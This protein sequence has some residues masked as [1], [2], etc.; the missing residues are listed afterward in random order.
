ML[1]RELNRIELA[2]DELNL[3]MALLSQDRLSEAEAAARR[4]VELAPGEPSGHVNLIAALRR[5][6]NQDKLEQAL[7]SLREQHPDIIKSALFQERLAK[8]PDFLGVSKILQR[9]ETKFE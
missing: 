8:D 1:S 2:R 6:N 4:A 3:C 5:L 7:L 9:L